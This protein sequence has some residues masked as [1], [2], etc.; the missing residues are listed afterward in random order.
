MQIEE[1]QI[2]HKFRN[3]H[4]KNVGAYVSGG[5][6]QTSTITNT[7]SIYD[8]L[9]SANTDVALSA[10]MGKVL[11]DTKIDETQLDDKLNTLKDVYLSKT[12]DDQA[13]GLITFNKG[14][15]AKT[16]QSSDE[17]LSTAS[18]GII[19]YGAVEEGFVATGIIEI[20]EAVG[21]AT[22]LGGLNNVDDSFDTLADGTFAF[23][24]KDGVLHPI[25]VSNIGGGGIVKLV[26]VSDGITT[27]SY[28]NDTFIK[29]NFTST[30]NGESTGSAL[31]TYTV[32]N[33]VIKATT[34]QQGETSFNVGQYLALGSNSVKVDVTDSYG[35]IRSI[36]YTIEAVSIS[37]SSTFDYSNPFSDAITYKFTPI[38]AIEKTVH[39]LVDGVEVG[40]MTTSYTNR[41]LTYSINKQT[42]G[43]HTLEVYMTADVENAKIESNHLYYELMCID[44]SNS[45]PVIASSYRGM[46]A[47]Q[48]STI[49]IPYVVYTPEKL[50]SSIT[51]SVNG[52][53]LSALTVSR[54]EQ[55]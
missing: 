32:N 47:E 11:Q 14:I 10:N 12:D 40:T 8:G 25:S 31:A 29:F 48:Y 36:T 21:G 37:V 13:A 4:L 46:E 19:E 1:K 6:S 20:S 55:V 45:N 53:I 23:E 34:I 49:Q 43:S 44:T 16:R 5:G 2:P 33:K 52:Q 24:M 28:G 18:T 9:D 7:V 22:T 41:Q 30:I 50:N 39:F 3:K 15:V 26:Y 27:V 35:T 38:G 54:T 42:H 51:L 17:L